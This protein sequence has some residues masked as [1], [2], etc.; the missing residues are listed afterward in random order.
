M[1]Y[2]PCM[3]LHSISITYIKDI[4]TNL[5]IKTFIMTITY[6]LLDLYVVF[7]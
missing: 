6:G 3:P 1:V 5:N 4:F 2:T 7:D